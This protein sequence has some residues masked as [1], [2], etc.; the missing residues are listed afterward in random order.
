MILLAL[1]LL[2]RKSE[3]ERQTPIMRF[4]NDSFSAPNLVFLWMVLGHFSQVKL[5]SFVGGQP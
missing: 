1:I 4:F 5:K 3:T 2:A